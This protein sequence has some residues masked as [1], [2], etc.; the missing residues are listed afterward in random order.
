MKILCLRDA[1]VIDLLAVLHVHRRDGWEVADRLLSLV[2]QQRVDPVLGGDAARTV[3]ITV[4]ADG[5][6]MMAR[7]DS[8]AAAEAAWAVITSDDVTVLQESSPAAA[9]VDRDTDD[10]EEI[11]FWPTAP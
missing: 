8:P 4:E 3:L 9:T 1:D 5:F 11:E 10:H 6:A 2:D 7:Y